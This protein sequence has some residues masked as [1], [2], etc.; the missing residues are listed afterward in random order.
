MPAIIHLFEKPIFAEKSIKFAEKVVSLLIMVNQDAVGNS[1]LIKQFRLVLGGKRK[2]RR[3]NQ[4]ESVE[5][6]LASFNLKLK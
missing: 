3:I 6:S 1:D 5:L 2:R 4:D